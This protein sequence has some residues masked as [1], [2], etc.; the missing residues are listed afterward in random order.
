MASVVTATSAPLAFDGA[1]T[2]DCQLLAGPTQD[3]N[4]MVQRSRASGAMTRL[5][6]KLEAM[7]LVRRVRGSRDRRSARL[8][9]TRAGRGMYAQVMRV[10]VNVLN[11]AQVVASER[12]AGKRYADA[13]EGHRPAGARIAA[14]RVGGSSVRRHQS[15][16]RPPRCGLDL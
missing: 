7:A 15:A 8:E 13:G 4:L 1:A 14:F 11:V 12:S 6:D 3:L 5:V 2:V 9:P 10:Q 16:I